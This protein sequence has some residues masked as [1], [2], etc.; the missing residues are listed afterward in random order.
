MFE[1]ILGKKL[2]AQG[3]VVSI[4]P[5]SQNI[6]FAAV[7]REQNALTAKSASYRPRAYDREFYDVL[8]KHIRQ[9]REN[10]PNMDLQKASLVL[11]DQ[12]FLL[13]MISIPMIHRKA[14]QHSLSL[15]VESI[16]KNADDLDL[17]TYTVQQT[18]QAATF[19]LAGVRRD[20]LEDVKLVFADNGITV[21]G[22]TFASNAM[23]NGAFALNSKLRGETFLLLDIKE[24][25][26]RFAFVVR[27]CTMGY[28]DL[29]FG[30]GIL[31]ESRLAAENKLFDHRAGELLVLNAKERARAKQLTMED[32]VP[33]VLSEDGL[34][35]ESVPED[36]YRRGG[37]RLPK[38]MLRP[39]P[40]TAEGYVYENFR[41]F[42]KW[43]LELINNNPSIVA[44]AKLDKVYVNLP[45]QYNFLFDVINH[46]RA[47]QGVTF[48]PLVAEPTEITFTENLE[49]YGGLFLDQFNEANTF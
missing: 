22:V 41:I 23:V 36:I 2:M 46:D 17:V 39:L 5:L 38:Y 21:T 35:E 10:Y 13:D 28:F 25:Y 12:L 11:P 4:D 48:A 31:Y 29:P 16:Y 14:M 37:R 20:L 26:S 3:S 7:N 30:H 44:L 33:N 1:N 19:G 9:Q 45:Q 34:A 47:E 49:L 18:K 8:A 42:I 6:L 43:A 24:H 32:V 15:A 40:E 27:G